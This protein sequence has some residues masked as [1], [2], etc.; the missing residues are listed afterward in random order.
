MPDS[1]TLLS[2][3]FVEAFRTLAPK[4]SVPETDVRYYP[5]AGLNHTIRLRSGRVHVRLSDIFKAAPLN[6][7]RALAFIL[8]AKLL[9]RRTPPFY[10]R[11]YRDY[12]CSPDVL[13]A[14]DL[15]RR[16]RGRKVVSTAQGRVYDLGRMFNRLNQR[17]FDGE[18]EQP[19]L[20]WSRRRTRTILGHHDGVHE[21]I[22]ISKTLDST[23]VP[24]WFV[25]YILYHEM[26]HIKHPARLINGRRY[27]HTKAFRTDEQRF[28]HFQDAQL[29]LDQIV[30]QRRTLRARAA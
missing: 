10:E 23:E 25:E 15:A 5:Y 28:P 4:R 17:F 3:L 9:R 20:T 19:T 16:Q 11:V 2:T 7:H 22:V 13:R 26:L 12:A 8:V 6:V 1:Q 14:S 24:E 21:T 18:L 27:Y 30:R 29:W